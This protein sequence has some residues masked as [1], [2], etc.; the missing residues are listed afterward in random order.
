LLLLRLACVPGLPAGPQAYS[1]SLVGGQIGEATGQSAGVF[2]TTEALRFILRVVH[3]SAYVEEQD[4]TEVGV[5]LELLDVVTVRTSPGT[6]VEPS[7]VVA[8]NVFAVF[9]KLQ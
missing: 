6:P 1:I 9:G 2:D 3:R 4:H 8:G 5:G 7:K